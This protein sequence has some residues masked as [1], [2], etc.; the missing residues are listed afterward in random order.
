[1]RDPLLEGVALRLQHAAGCGDGGGGGGGEC[2]QMELAVRT[3][4]K[5]WDS[6]RGGVEMRED[7][8]EFDDT[9]VGARFMASERA[10]THRGAIGER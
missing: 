7:G 6:G 9:T 10:V 1:M 8:D 3:R 4:R 2:G 5:R